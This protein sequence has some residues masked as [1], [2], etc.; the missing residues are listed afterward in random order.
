GL[1]VLAVATRRWS[2]LPAELSPSILERDLT[3]QGFVGLLDPP[4]DEARAA[5]ETCR[6]AGIVPV[7]VTGDPPLTARAGA[8]RPGRRPGPD[9]LLTGREMEALSPAELAQRVAHVR[10]YARVTPEQKLRIVEALQANGELVA[11]T[12]DGV[13]D[14]PALKQA[15]IGVSMGRSGTDAARE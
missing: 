9:A 5:I 12:G 4:R 6:Q 1:R 2:A 13:N 11:M 3:L 7:M 8:S 14:A 15:D 10:V